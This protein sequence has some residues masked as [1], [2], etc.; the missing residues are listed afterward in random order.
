MRQPDPLRRNLP[1]GHLGLQGSHWCSRSEVPRHGLPGDLGLA[2]LLQ[3]GPFLEGGC[4]IG[5][6]AESQVRI[7]HVVQCITYVL[8]RQSTDPAT[9]PQ[10]YAP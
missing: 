2:D 3:F 10:W 6:E 7:F 5:G 1:A 4:Q 9:S 8:R